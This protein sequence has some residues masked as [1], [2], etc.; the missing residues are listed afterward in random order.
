MGNNNDKNFRRCFIASLQNHS[1]CC[2]WDLGREAPIMRSSV[3]S[4]STV[5]EAAVQ[6]VVKWRTRLTTLQDQMRHVNRSTS[7]RISSSIPIVSAPMAGHAGGRLA[8]AVCNAGGIGM[9]GAGHWLG[10]AMN[11]DDQSTTAKTGLDKLKD[12]IDIFREQNDKLN[13]NERFPLCIGFIGHSTFAN[14]ASNEDI[15]NGG[16][17]ERLEYVLRTY[18]PSMVQFF[19]P[20]ISHRTLTKLQSQRNAD[21]Q[22]ESNIQLVHR[23][24]NHKTKVFVQVGTVAEA[25][26]AVENNVDGIIVQGSEAGG[27]GVRRELGSGTLSLV[28]NVIHLV[29]GESGDVGVRNNNR[30][31]TSSSIIM[32]PT[33]HTIPILAAGGIVN[34]TTM[35]A[36]MAL[37]CDGVVIGT[38]FWAS[39]ESIGS[40]MIKDRL[41]T[42]QSCDDV[43]RTT[44][45]DWIQNTYSKTPW[46][47][48][49]D[50]V[51]AIKNE[52]YY[53]WEQ[54][55]HELTSALRKTDNDIVPPY[56]KAC[57][58][59]NT[60]IVLVHA[61]EGVGQIHSIESAHDIV[62]TTS[63]DAIAVIQNLSRTI[64]YPDTY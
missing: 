56:R 9:I 52:T 30:A 51:G 24:T 6:G 38:R 40:P 26:D 19:A 32:N 64:L 36:A 62:L 37:G 54:S 45:F 12:E 55:S 8:A 35:A 10:D 44:T 1:R 22:R 25:I 13:P 21:V 53:R 57:Q 28:A 49:Y 42:A 31:N 41:V 23:C 59:G 5:A 7:S 16:G 34:G 29:R 50:S 18:Q 27:H 17:W 46:P 48:P 11:D 3:S 39:S 33:N 58:D 43:V 47:Q 4:T 63:S 2:I 14:T 60:D 20:A 61:G 15:M